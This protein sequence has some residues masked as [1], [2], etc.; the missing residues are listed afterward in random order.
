MSPV[1]FIFDH[2]TTK[3]EETKNLLID[4]YARGETT[5]EIIAFIKFLQKHAHTFTSPTKHTFDVCGTGGSG[6]QRINLS[7]ALTLKLSEKFSIAKHGGKASSGKV[8]SFD[9]IE[10]LGLEKAINGSE[11]RTQLQEKNCAF[12]YA[13]AFH[14]ILKDLAPIRKSISHRT[15]FNLLGP[16]L[17]PVQNLTGQMIGCSDKKMM[18]RQAEALKYFGRNALFV[19]DTVFGLDDVSIGGE[20]YFVEVLNG[21]ITEGT[22]IPEDYDL[23]RSEFFLE[24][25]GGETA[26]ANGAIFSD[27]INGTAKESPQNFLEINKRVAE[28]FFGKCIHNPLPLE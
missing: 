28:E 1:Q 24:I 17:S 22:F 19:H 4:M 8:G 2:A 25:A 7:T 6:K 18:I 10:K 21:Q 9:L 15:I 11:A 3:P 5:E 26:E 14:P 27:L 13:P 20:T 23:P 12:L 16:L